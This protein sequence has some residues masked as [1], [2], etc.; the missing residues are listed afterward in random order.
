MSLTFIDTNKLPKSKSTDSGE[1]TEILNKALCGAE[2]V[3][4]KL[5]WLRN[6][7]HLDSGRDSKEH[8]LFYLMEG[9][10]TITLNSKDYGVK[11]GA[12]VYLGP[13]ESATIRQSGSAPLK[14]LHLI[15]PKLKS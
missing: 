6:G 12:G 5:H 7:Q 3:V 14:L 1:V 8:Q 2:N 11:K 9:A 13:M 10:G 4:G 15:V